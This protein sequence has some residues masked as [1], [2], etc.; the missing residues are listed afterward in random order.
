MNNKTKL[1]FTGWIKLTKQEKEIFAK[2]VNSYIEKSM[3]EQRQISDAMSRTAI[4]LGP[5]GNACPC[6]GK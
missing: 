3:N 4:N 2:E 1:V 6:C 5:L